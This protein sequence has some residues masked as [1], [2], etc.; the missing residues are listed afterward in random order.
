MTRAIA[1]HLEARERDLLDP[2]T[3]H[4]RDRLE[5]LLTPD[6]REF[7]SSGRSFDRDAILAELLTETPRA[8]SLYDFVCQQL[9]ETTALVTYRTEHHTPGELHPQSSLRSSVWMARQDRWQ[10]IFHQGTR[11]PLPAVQNHC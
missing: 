8:I 1:D 2:A 6:F 3:R 10:M 9:S 7:G 5:L 11:V 4:S